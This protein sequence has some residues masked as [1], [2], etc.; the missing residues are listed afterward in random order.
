ML[1]R[2]AVSFADVSAEALRW[3][4]GLP[5]QPALAVRLIAAGAQTVELRLLGASHQV[6]VLD[7]GRCIWSET[8]ACGGDG[9][10]LP[11]AVH[12]GVYR[13]RAAVRQLS[14]ADLAAQAQELMAGLAQ[15]PDAL[16]GVFPEPT[17]T[18]VT[19]LLV[20][21]AGLGWQTWHGYP[22]TGQLVH[23]TSTVGRA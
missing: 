6:R 21:R 14:T 16:L 11:P 12:Q 10:P 3:A 4:L 23:T 17:G 20:D 2:L 1:T 7:A 22:Q 15:H 5:P 19:A 13:F 8:V 18:A 9:V